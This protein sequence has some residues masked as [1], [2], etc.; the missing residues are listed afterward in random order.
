MLLW[1]L[2]INSG[3]FSKGFYS[4]IFRKAYCKNKLIPVFGNNYILTSTHV[5][6]L[7]LHYIIVDAFV[8]A[9]MALKSIVPTGATVSKSLKD[10]GRY[11]KLTTLSYY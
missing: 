2:K 9:P 4:Q 10:R 1:H 5:I 11:L 6:Q 3:L 7:S 8:G